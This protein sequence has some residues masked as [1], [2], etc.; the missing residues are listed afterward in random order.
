MCKYKPTYT[1]STHTDI[2]FFKYVHIKHPHV[3]MTYTCICIH[4][5]YTSHRYKYFIYIDDTS[6]YTCTYTRTY[7]R[8]NTRIYTHASHIARSKEI[9]DMTKEFRDQVRKL[10]LEHPLINMDKYLNCDI[11]KYKEFEEFIKKN[12]QLNNEV[13][14]LINIL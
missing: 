13:Y 1:Y 2:Q 6:I 14:I 12:V 8:I 3:C 10:Q 7:T 4:C 11:A 5:M 9:R